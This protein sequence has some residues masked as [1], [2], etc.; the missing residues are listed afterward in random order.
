LEVPR[1][2]LKRPVKKLGMFEQ[3]DVNWG[4][5]EAPPPKPFEELIPAAQSL[6]SPRG[7]PFG[8]VM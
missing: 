2:E 6:D 5:K 8:L 1:S 3:A 7:I 4:F